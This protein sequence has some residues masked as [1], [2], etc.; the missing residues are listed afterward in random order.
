MTAR[1]GCLLATVVGALFLMV[2]V[3]F[4]LLVSRAESRV[5]PGVPVTL[6]VSISADTHG[7]VVRERLTPNGDVTL[8]DH[9]DVRLPK[10]H[11]GLAQGP[12]LD[13]RDVTA[14]GRPQTMVATADGFHVQAASLPHGGTALTFGYRVPPTRL[15]AVA[16]IGG[17]GGSVLVTRIVVAAEPAGWRCVR[18]E[19]SATVF[20]SCIR[21]GNEVDS[22][23]YPGRQFV[24][25]APDAVEPKWAD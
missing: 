16:P 23:G 1:R 2:P 19:R 12:A 25:R 18:S 13:Y 20:S 6:T 14:D 11:P 8:P 7:A 21:R 10:Q 17:F 15:G 3:V 4:V 22:G 9:V 24:W 5:K